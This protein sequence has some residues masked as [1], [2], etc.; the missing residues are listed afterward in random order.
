MNS[1]KATPSFN[2]CWL[3]LWMMSGLGARSPAAGDSYEIFIEG[4]LRERREQSRPGQSV[5]I[6]PEDETRFNTNAQLQRDP[7]FILNGDQSR[8]TFSLPLFRGQDARS[9]HI[10]VDDVELVDPFS[11]LPMIDEIDL[12]AFGRMTVHKGFAPWNVPVMEPGGVIQ[13]TSRQ[14]SKVEGGGRFGTVSGVAGWGH[15]SQSNDSSDQRIYFRRAVTRG[16]YN[17]YD[18]N[19]TLLNPT[20]DKMTRRGNNDRQSMQSLGQLRWRNSQVNL[21]GFFWGQMSDGGIPAGRAGADGH[22]R[23]HGQTFVMTSSANVDVSSDVMMGLHVGHFQAVRRFKDPSG[24][25][26]FATSRRLQ[27]SSTNFQITTHGGDD[28]WRWLLALDRGEAKT[29][30]TSTYGQDAY[31][32]DATKNKLFIGNLVNV[33]PGGIIEVKGDVQTSTAKSRNI[34]GSKIVNFSEKAASSGSIGW[35]Q[36][37]DRLWVYSQLGRT[38]RNPSLMERVGNG[39]EIEGALAVNPEISNAAEVG[40]RYRVGLAPGQTLSFGAAIWGRD[41]DHVIRID[42]V[43]ATR[44]RAR[45]VG[46]QAYRGVEG[47]LEVGS[48]QRGLESAVSF[49]KATQVTSGRLVPRVPMWQAVVGPRW[50]VAED[51]MVRVFSHFVGRTYDDSGNTREIGWV[52]THD[53]SID[54][55]PA[56]GFWRI[57]LTVQNISNVVAL[58]CRDVSTNQNDGKIAYSDFSGEPMTGRSWMFS[59]SASL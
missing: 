11:G 20:D 14:A 44:W 45:N 28:R 40:A 36:A 2:L 53:A 50:S 17:F 51:V 1:R 13:F 26:S 29:K 21:K 41:N 43:S 35:S 19:G 3:I 48:E 39:A 10:F 33:R 31:A 24:D 27:S 4:V 25:I 9:T 5:V 7:S 56:V 52:L 30:M 12:R 22:A 37:D 57:G 59:L 42:K 54:W 23:I 32:P 46:R 38:E 6:S 49:L 16:D 34:E 55:T 8:P 15:W 18:D 47:R 58:P